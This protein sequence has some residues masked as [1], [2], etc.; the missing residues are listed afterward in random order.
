MLDRY[1]YQHRQVPYNPLLLWCMLYKIKVLH[2][3]DMVTVMLEK[4][5]YN[6]NNSRDEI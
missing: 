1:R 2:M 3:Y 4:K 6:N 5:S